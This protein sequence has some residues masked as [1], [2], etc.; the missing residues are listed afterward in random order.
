MQADRTAFVGTSHSFV[1]EALGKFRDHSATI[2]IIGLGYVG[3]P[4]TVAVCGRGYRTLGFD[5]DAS[6][7]ATLRSGGALARRG[8]YVKE[9]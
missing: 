3:L 5:I 2:G 6:K 8:G 4:L 9:P 1:E 7:V